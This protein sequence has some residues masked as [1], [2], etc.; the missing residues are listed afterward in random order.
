MFREYSDEELAHMYQNGEISE[1]EYQNSL[2]E[3]RMLR[4]SLIAVG[5][6]LFLIIVLLL[7]GI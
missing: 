5:F 4:N 7:L 6:G 2:Y 3:N 1:I